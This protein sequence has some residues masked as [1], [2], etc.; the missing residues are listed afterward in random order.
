VDAFAVTYDDTRPVTARPDSTAGLTARA[1][2]HVRTFGASAV[3]VSPTTWGRAEVVA[4][5][6]VQT[7]R[8]F[9]QRHRAW[10][11][12]ATVG[13]RFEAATW[14]PRVRAGMAYGS[15]D[16]QPFDTT[17]GTFF[18]LLPSGDRV[19]ALNAYALMNVRDTWA[20]ADASP[21]AAIDLQVGARRLHLAQVLDR[22]YQGSGATARSGA[23]FGYQGRRSS[24]S[25]DLGAIVEGSV[26]WRPRRWWTLRG[27][28]GRMSGGDVVVGLF[29]SN[30]LLTGW[31]ESTVRF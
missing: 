22:W 7:G 16:G 21:T 20:S 12:T 4:W 6:A 25:R 1:D 10:A 24:G 13:H 23:Y 31:L 9:E 28:L 15:G 3:S 26:V 8:W 2:V 18:P 30:R 5:A 14:R 29:R 27:Y 19:S 11:S 17:H